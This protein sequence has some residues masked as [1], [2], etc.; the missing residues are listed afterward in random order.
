MAPTTLGSKL[1]FNSF[2]QVGNIA[3]WDLA[4]RSPLPLF[5]LHQAFLQS[6]YISLCFYSLP[7]VD[8][9][10]LLAHLAPFHYRFLYIR[11]ATNNHTIQSTI[12]C[13]EIS[14]ANVIN[15]KLF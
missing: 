3:G 2:L 7:S 8:F 11:P 13:F 6:A 15:P 10:F 9:V 14:S 12:D 5:H 1:F 4:L